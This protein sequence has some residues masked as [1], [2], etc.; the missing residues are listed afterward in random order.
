MSNLRCFAADTSLCCGE[1]DTGE[2]LAEKGGHVDALRRIRIQKQRRKSGKGRDGERDCEPETEE[3]E[4]PQQAE[5]LIGF[6]G[7]SSSERK[8]E[9]QVAKLYCTPVKQQ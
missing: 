1:G 4:A 3:V 7:Y 8:I 6:Y 2:H 9:P 5:Q